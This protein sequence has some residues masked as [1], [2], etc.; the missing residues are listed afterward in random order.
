MN[1]PEGYSYAPSPSPF[2]NHIGNI[3]YRQVKVS[4]AVT[5]FWVAMYMEDHHVNSW[6]L[7]HGSVMACMAEIGTAAPAWVADGPPVVAIDMGMQ[8]IAAPKKGELLEVCSIADKRTRS[9]V[10]TSAKGYVAGHIV[11]SANSIQKILKG[12]G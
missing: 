10:F 2:V 6:G 9:L 7:A 8:F 11:F 3:F 5:E 1:I 4:E 12:Q